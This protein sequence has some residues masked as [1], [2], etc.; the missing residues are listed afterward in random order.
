MAFGHS[1]TGLFSPDFKWCSKTGPFDIQT[2]FNHLKSG[3]VQY[4]DPHCTYDKMLIGVCLLCPIKGFL[5]AAPNFCINFNIFF[6]HFRSTR[7]RSRTRSSPSSRRTQR[8][9]RVA[10]PTSASSLKIASTPVSLSGFCTFLV[11]YFES[12]HQ[13]KLIQIPD[14]DLNGHNMLSFEMAS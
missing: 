4:L 9:R 12:L 11:N 3:L 5:K 1:K 6:C 7:P 10:W 8:P 13:F 14:R 2:T